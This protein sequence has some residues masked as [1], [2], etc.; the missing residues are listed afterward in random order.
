VSSRYTVAE[1]YSETST[2]NVGINFSNGVTVEAG[3]EVFQNTPNPFQAETLIGF[4]LPVDSEVMLTVSDVSGKVLTVLRG[5]YAAGY[6]TINLTKQQLGGVSGVLS[7]T[8]TAG[9]HTATK[10]M[11]VVK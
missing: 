4:N 5:D 7:Y 2:K 3:F 11:V 6:N 10:Q 8:L 1:A 9:E